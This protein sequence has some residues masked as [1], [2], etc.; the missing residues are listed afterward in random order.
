MS[1]FFEPLALQYGREY[2]H[3]V[4]EECEGTIEPAAGQLAAEEFDDVSI[5]TVTGGLDVDLSSVLSGFAAVSLKRVV[6]RIGAFTLIGDA[7]ADF[8]WTIVQTITLAGIGLFGNGGTAIFNGTTVQIRGAAGVLLGAQ[9]TVEGGSVIMEAGGFEIPVTIKCRPKLQIG[10]FADDSLGDAPPNLSYIL[11][12][13]EDQLAVAGGRVNLGT[14]VGGQPLIL[15]QVGQ[16]YPRADNRYF[17]RST[18]VGVQTGQIPPAVA[19]NTSTA[20]RLHPSVFVRET[21]KIR[22]FVGTGRILN[23]PLPI[24]SV[25]G[26]PQLFDI[27]RPPTHSTWDIVIDSSIVTVTVA[28][29]VGS[30]LRRP[31]DVWQQV[32][33]RLLQAT[34]AKGSG[35]AGALQVFEVVTDD[36]PVTNSFF[37]RGLVRG[38]R[39]MQAAIFR[40]FFDADAATPI[41]VP[42]LQV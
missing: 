30:D 19:Q 27:V 20:L 17:I 32:W 11:G 34:N 24:T 18:D 8:Q 41:A 28:H 37:S 33:V 14:N 40:E 7:A 2:A 9:A 26:A 13:T 38:L 35:I 5:A 29:P 15:I 6:L 16:A 36:P 31:R 10:V 23:Q 39:Y 12:A 1:E 22:G 3:D 25:G 42:H 4:T 21:E